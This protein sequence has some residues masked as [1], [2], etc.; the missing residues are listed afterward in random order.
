M[1]DITNDRWDYTGRAAGRRCNDAATSRIFFID[2]NSIN[3]EPVVGEDRIDC[4]S[5][6]F[7]NEPQVYRSGPSLNL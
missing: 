6:R 4:I 5:G 2:C 7:I 1:L 3:R